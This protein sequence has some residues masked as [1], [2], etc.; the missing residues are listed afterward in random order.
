MNELKQRKTE[1]RIGYILVGGKPPPFG[2]RL[3]IA[4][5]S[6]LYALSALQ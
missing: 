5:C 3:C 1:N 4:K 6:V 2:T